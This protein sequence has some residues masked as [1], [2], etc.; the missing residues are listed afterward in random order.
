MPAILRQIHPPSP[1]ELEAARK[2]ILSHIPNQE[3]YFGR[4][5]AL[6]PSSSCQPTYASVEPAH[7]EYPDAQ[8]APEANQN[9]SPKRDGPGDVAPMD[10]Q[11]I[12]A[13][14]LAPSPLKLCY[15]GCNKSFTRN[16][17]LR[18]HWERIQEC[19]ERHAK[20]HIRAI[21]SAEYTAAAYKLRNPMAYLGGRK[22]VPK[23]L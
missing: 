2:K 14:I 8:P 6:R 13:D 17:G 7:D 23:S 4:Q 15:G 19:G 21:T 20:A 10:R 16:Q 22:I 3:E 1:E 9:M 18:R 11:A 5:N 12:I